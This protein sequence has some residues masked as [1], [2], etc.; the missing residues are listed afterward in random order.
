MWRGIRRKKRA[1]AIL[2]TDLPVP[3]L[4]QKAS[5]HNA[6]SSCRS[7]QSIEEKKVMT[8]LKTISYQKDCCIVRIGGMT[9]EVP[10][11]VGQAIEDMTNHM[12]HLGECPTCGCVITQTCSRCKQ[13]KSNGTPASVK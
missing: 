5:S 12:R 8:L 7:Y 3:E 4:G 9:Y 13:G 10:K 2:Q 6:S 1:R 11:P